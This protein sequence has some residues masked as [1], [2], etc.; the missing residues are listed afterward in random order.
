VFLL[1]QF[2]LTIPRELRDAAT[3]T[4]A[5]SFRIYWQIVMPL[6]R[7]ALAT[8]IGLRVPGS[9]TDSWGP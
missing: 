9:Y 5:M 8:L 3:S 7:P 1:R 2:F 6:S 4:G